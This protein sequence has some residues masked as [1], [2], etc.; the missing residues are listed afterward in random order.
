MATRFLRWT[1]ADEIQKVKP[2]AEQIVQGAKTHRE[3]AVRIYNYVRDEV[4]FGFTAEF[5]RASPSYTLEQKRGHCNPKGAL[6][7]AMLSAVNVQSRM[8]IIHIHL[9][10]L[11]TTQ[12]ADIGVHMFMDVQVDPDK[13]E[14]VTVDGYVV[15]RPVVAAGIET[16]KKE[17]ENVGHFT[18]IGALSE[19]DGQKPAM[20]QYVDNAIRADDFAITIDKD[21]DLEAFYMSNNYPQ[22]D[23]VL[24]WLGSKMISWFFVPW[25]N[26]SINQQRLVGNELIKATK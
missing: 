1:F 11:I 22:R 18:H 7:H 16:L 4:Q 15:D 12:F 19:W 10:P 13:D 14:W 20:S 6:F 8:R 24:S 5:D 17:G 9:N 26:R 25:T 21:E 23:A 3:K 2:V